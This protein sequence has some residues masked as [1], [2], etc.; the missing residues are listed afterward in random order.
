MVVISRVRL[1]DGDEAAAPDVAFFSGLGAT[2]GALPTR[3]RN[4]SKTFVL[5]VR[6]LP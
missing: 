3:F 4:G 2:R 6:L 5:L 1:S